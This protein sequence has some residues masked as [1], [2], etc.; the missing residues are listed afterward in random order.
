MD[1]SARGSHE[2]AAALAGRTWVALCHHPVLNRLGQVVTTA[3]TNLDLH[4]IARASRSYGLA[5]FLIITPV[6]RQRHLAERIVAHWRGDG[7]LG[8]NPYRAS[9]VSLVQVVPDL[10]SATEVVAACHGEPALVVATAARR[11]AHGIFEAQFLGGR[12]SD[13]RP[14][15]L[16]FGTGWGLAEAALA[17]AEIRLHPILGP[18]DYNHLSVRSAVSIY[19][20]RLFG[21]RY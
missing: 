4:D 7:A 19:L 2:G 5:G 11:S 15:M 14:V 18:S 8:R 20:D 9:A 16:L 12:E 1:L 17:R 3:I 21:M 10:E 6:E 13:T